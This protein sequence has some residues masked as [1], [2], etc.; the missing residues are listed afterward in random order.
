MRLRPFEGRPR[1]QT[2]QEVQ[3]DKALQKSLSYAATRSHLFLLEKQPPKQLQFCCQIFQ[4]SPIT[5]AS[6]T[7]LLDEFEDRNEAA[8]FHT[9]RGFGVREGPKAQPEPPTRFFLQVIDVFSKQIIWHGC[10]QE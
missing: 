5:T 7:R 2:H 9:D 3:Q 10:F 8:G 6:Q 4:A 1:Y